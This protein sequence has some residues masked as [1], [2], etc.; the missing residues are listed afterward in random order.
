MRFINY[1]NENLEKI[2]TFKDLILS[3]CRPFLNDIKKC[4]HGNM[5]Y[6]GRKENDFLIRKR[7]RQDRIP[8]DTPKEIHLTLDKMFQKSFGIKARSQ[9]VFALSNIAGYSSFYGSPYYIFPIG[10]Y[11]IVWSDQIHDLY[12][13]L[14]DWLLNY[15]EKFRADIKTILVPYRFG[16]SIT[17]F[18]EMHLSDWL[19]E[20]F[21]LNTLYQKGNL[22]QALN[23]SSEIMVH[24]KEYIGIRCEMYRKL[25][26]KGH[27]SILDWILE[28]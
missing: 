20:N 27:P 9:T 26:I 7:V 6:S 23:I 1:L 12:G 5:M 25:N 24:C 11:E 21:P 2:D 28:K 17:D 4:P 19:E 3:E 10:K 15:S 14:I 13:D 16:T 22:C 8:K 18:N